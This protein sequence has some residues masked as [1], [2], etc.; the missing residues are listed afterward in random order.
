M[1]HFSHREYLVDFWTRNTGY[2]WV[3]HQETINQWVVCDHI[4]VQY[5]QGIFSDFWVT[6][7]VHFLWHLVPVHRY[8]IKK[9][10][11]KNSSWIWFYMYVGKICR[12]YELYL[13]IEYCIVISDAQASEIQKGN[14]P[15]VLSKLECFCRN[16][17]ELRL[18]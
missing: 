7:S 14:D 18:V 5:L 6:P 8:S 1:S 15:P 11:F 12:K 4:L 16:P 10:M 2:R 3:W 9:L 17:V 13:S